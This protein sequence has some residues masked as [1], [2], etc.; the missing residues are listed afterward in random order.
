[1]NLVAGTTALSKG[2]VEEECVPDCLDWQ[3]LS[4]LLA[5]TGRSLT[6][7]ATDHEEGRVAL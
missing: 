5:Q 4:P 3:F 6:G 2:A 7:G 1:M